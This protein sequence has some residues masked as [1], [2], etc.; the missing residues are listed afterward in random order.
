MSTTQAVAELFRS[1]VRERIRQLRQCSYAELRA[2]P[3]ESREAVAIQD[4]Q[5]PITVAI[6]R[7]SSERLRVVVQARWQNWALG[8]SQFGG[9]FLRSKDE[10]VESMEE[11][12]FDDYA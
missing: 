1:A 2:M 10:H 8:P 5:V 4:Q 3:V 11:P 12:H 6:D 9:E 7:I